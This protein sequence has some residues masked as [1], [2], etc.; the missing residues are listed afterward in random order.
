MSL[1]PFLWFILILLLSAPV[2]Y[3]AGRLPLGNPNR[4]SLAQPVALLGLVLAWPPL[5]LAIM[6]VLSTGPV[7][8]AIGSVLLHIDGLSLVL[9]GPALALATVVAIYSRTLIAG[10]SGEARY[11]ALLLILVACLSGLGIAA[12]LFNLW[13]W[14]EATTLASYFL[15]GFHYTQ[16]SAIEATVKYLVQSTLGSVCILLG[17]AFCLLQTGSLSLAALRQTTLTPLLAAAGVLGLVGFGV[18]AALVPLHTW[19]PDAHSQ[20]PSGISAMLSGIVIESGLVALL[21]LISPFLASSQSWGWLL[22]WLG[23]INLLVGN[24]MALRQSQV[25]RLLAYSSLS[26]I[27]YMV[28][29]LGIAGA[30][31]QDAGAQGAFF[32]LVNHALMKGLAFLAAGILLYV[33]QS[34]A[35]SHAPLLVSDLSGVAGRYPLVAFTFSL[36]LF[37]LAG[38]PPLAGFMS[39]WQIFLAGMQSGSALIIGFVIFAALNSVLSLAYYAPLVNNLYRRQPS[40][41]VAQGQ[42][43]PASANL[44]LLALAAAIVLLGLWPGLVNGLTA[45]AAVAF[46]G[47]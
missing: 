17:I 11:Y 23:S 2:V 4:P 12:D 47:H 24:L 36:A 29:G 32:H 21:R 7:D 46:L 22:L 15:V 31:G 19:L 14:F 3:Y 38:L 1:P 30:V 37:G 13:L 10:E 34:A 16:K 25:K 5:I 43:V 42:A 39:K 28:L 33:L 40:A 45:S 26:Q 41:L 27:G 18:K 6:Q 44:P 35:T 9:G 20:A 8:Y